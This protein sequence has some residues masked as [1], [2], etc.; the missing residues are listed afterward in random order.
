MKIIQIKKT[1]FLQENIKEEAIEK[2]LKCKGWT[3]RAKLSLLYDLAQQ[4]EKING[5]ILEIG[6]AWGRSTVLLAFA[7]TK[8]IWS[9]DPHTGGIAYIKRGKSKAPL[10][11]LIVIFIDKRWLTG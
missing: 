10:M 11:N 9:I 3:S 8:I 4:T 1:N 2:A 6:S 7:S 5:D